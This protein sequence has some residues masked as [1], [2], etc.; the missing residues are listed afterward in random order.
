[1]ILIAGFSDNMGFMFLLAATVSI[2]AVGLIVSGMSL[3]KHGVNRWCAYASLVYFAGLLVAS[4]AAALADRAAAA[5]DAEAMG[6]AQFYWYLMG[7]C[8]AYVLS[9]LM[10]LIGLIQMRRRRRKWTHGRRRG[11]WIFWLSVFSILITGV[12]CF[13]HS[14][15]LIYDRLFK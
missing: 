2:P 6:P 5:S 9:A 11:L 12:W 7:C 14:N 15:Q 1:M 4:I 3:P 13:A 10:A 8:V